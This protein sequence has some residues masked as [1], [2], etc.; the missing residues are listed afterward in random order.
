[1]KIAF[2]YSPQGSQK[3]GMGKDLYDQVEAI[4]HTF[5]TAG[6]YLN[7]D[8]LEI[9][10]KNE[11]KLN[12]TRYVQTALFTFQV[13]ITDYLKDQGITASGS[14]GLSL[15]E[16]AALYNVGVFDFYSGLQCVEHRAFFMN[17]A[18]QRQV[19][20][21]AAI[22][23]DKATV[24]KLTQSLQDIYLANHN[25]ENQCV[26]SGSKEGI[27]QAQKKA[28]DFGIKRL[29]VLNTSGAFHSPL[30]AEAKN[31]FSEYLNYVNLKAPA[32]ELYLNTTGKKYN[33]ENLKEEMANHLIHPVRFH[34]G[35]MAM[36]KE[37]YNT[38]LEIGPKATL[39]AFVKKLSSEVKTMH[40]HDITSLNET[41]KELKD[42]E[43]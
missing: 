34:E 36:L 24:E 38:F 16:Y 29:R 33:D 28:S 39:S 18:T 12:S 21:M 30:M 40:I 27:E 31:H 43:G 20:Q 42:Y 9:M 32:A 8:L 22:K 25:S 41:L 26:I 1:M 15:G 13:A 11:K 7:Y 4:K 2:L 3:V 37:G 35:L 10:F 19:G 14:I 17:Q 23:S 5:D 6:R